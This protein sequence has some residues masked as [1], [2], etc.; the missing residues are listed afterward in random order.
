ME[1]KSLIIVDFEVLRASGASKLLLDPRRTSKTRIEIH[2]N[3]VL[4]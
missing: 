2:S 1:G 3:A 4:G